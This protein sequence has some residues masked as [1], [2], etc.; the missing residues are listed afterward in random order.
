[1]K[2]LCDTLKNHD[3][4]T[5]GFSSAKDALAALDT[6]KF[7][8]L[9]AD[10]MMPEMSGIE[11]LQA[12]QECDPL[13]VGIIMTGQGTIDTAVQ[14][15]KTGAL[16][17][18]LKPFKLSVVLPVLARALAVRR[19]RLENAEL[20]RRVQQHTAEIEAANKELTCLNQELES[21]SY[22]V[23]HDLRNPLNAINGFSDILLHDFAAQMPS[24]AQDLLQHVVR[25]AR[26]MGQLIEDLLRLSHLGR[27][28]LSKQPVNVAALVKEVVDGLREQQSAP[29]VVDVRI[30][31]LPGCFGDPSLLNQVFINLLSNAF[32][33]TSHREQALVEVG[34]QLQDGEHVYF[35]RD[36]GAG[37]DMRHAEKLFGV[38]Q[39][40][41]RNDEFAGTGVG[42]SIVQR[43]LQRHGGRIW[44]EAEVG[45]GAA[46]H[47]TLAE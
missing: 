31:D 1:M 39:R 7:D 28:P 12:A 35:V 22:S 14:A 33:F 19:L 43:I 15:I 46:F 18:I 16:D 24:K 37:F 21:F 2:A 8:L 34:C 41:H 29:R 44:A 11:L 25:S 30:G 10:L 3:Y 38:F 4:E 20:Q 27:Q 36:N 40:L 9:L 17:Y 26:R 5:T 47:F 13:L 45:K 6:A 42:L 23:S 32:K